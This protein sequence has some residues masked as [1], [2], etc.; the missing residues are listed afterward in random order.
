MAIP[1]KFTGL[2][3]KIVL[4]TSL[5]FFASYIG[6][7]IYNYYHA[8]EQYLKATIENFLPVKVDNIYRAL[9]NKLN[10]GIAVATALAQSEIVTEWLK[11][12]EEDPERIANYLKRTQAELNLNF[13]DLQI[14]LVGFASDKTRNSYNRYKS[15][16]P[17]PERPPWLRCRVARIGQE[18]PVPRSS[19]LRTTL[20]FLRTPPES[21]WAYHRG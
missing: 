9:S 18:T 15:C 5:L 19:R 14:D 21:V 13:S 17:F 11:G 16:R 8:R 12:D 1:A 20:S 7:I 2:N 3:L 4:G 6:L 10:S